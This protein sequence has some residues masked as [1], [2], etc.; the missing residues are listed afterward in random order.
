MLVA[1][2][3]FS[4]WCMAVFRYDG[5]KSFENVD[6]VFGAEFRDV[7]FCSCADFFVDSFVGVSS[8]DVGGGPSKDFA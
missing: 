5:Q 1:K 6:E 8:V 3:D 2:C 7:L 4:G